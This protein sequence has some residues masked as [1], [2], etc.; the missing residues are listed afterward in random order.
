MRFFAKVHPQY[1][2]K[3]PG[4]E[5]PDIHEVYWKN[6]KIQAYTVKRYYTNI[7]GYLITDIFDRAF[8]LEN[9]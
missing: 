1:D 2:P 6:N 5:H 7:Q 3:K 8:M 9:M 4:H